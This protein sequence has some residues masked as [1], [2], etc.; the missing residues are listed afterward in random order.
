MAQQR[1]DLRVDRGIVDHLDVIDVLRL[2]QEEARRPVRGARA[3]EEVRV[4]CRDDALDEQLARPAV[5]GVQPVAASTGRGPSTRSGRAARTSAQTRSTVPRSAASSPSTAPRKWTPAAPRVRAAARCS[6][7]RAATRAARSHVGSHVPFEP[8]VRTA[9]STWA[10]ARAHCA[11]VAP[12]PN[13]MSSGCAPIASTRDG[14]R[15][16]HVRSRRGRRLEIG[17][18]VHEIVGDVDVEREV[19]VAHDA[20]PEPEPACLGRVAAER[21]WSV[22][23]A[24]LAAVGTES[25]GVPSSR[26]QGTSATTGRAPSRAS[27]SSPRAYGRSA[28]ATTTR[29][30]PA[31]RKWSRPAAAAASRVPGSS[32]TVECRRT[33]QSRTSGSDDTTTTGRG[34]AACTHPLGQSPGQRRPLGGVERVGEAGFAEREGADRHDDPGAGG[35]G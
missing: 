26:W 11:N 29:E 24:E 23:E 13:S 31:A 6:S 34:A 25:T 28:C 10:P 15:A 35:A 32:S 5:V 3:G 33:A 20:Q 17:G 22:G 1:G 30:Q 4:T 7:W 27:R 16:H 8:S 14:T 9:S 12:H 18:E 19:A 21:T 2:E